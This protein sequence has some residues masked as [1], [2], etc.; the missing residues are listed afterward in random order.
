[1]TL[2]LFFFLI[3]TFGYSPL[4]LFFL[5]IS[6]LILT[7]ITLHLIFLATSEDDHQFSFSSGKS[8]GND[9]K[10]KKDSANGPVEERD[11]F[12]APWTILRVLLYI[13][14]IA[15]TLKLKYEALESARSPKRT[16]RFLCVLP[17]LICVIYYFSISDVFVAWVF[18]NYIVLLPSWALVKQ[19]L[20]IPKA[21]KAKA[22]S[23]K[24]PLPKFLHKH[25]YGEEKL[26]SE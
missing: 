24:I 19:Q 16:T 1:M 18:S 2:N 7:G 11:E 9:G 6:W 4:S 3:Y 26:K 22:E 12:I 25:L 17:V 5:F 13:Y 14:K 8:Q 23:V 21:W 20:V 15:L 10:A